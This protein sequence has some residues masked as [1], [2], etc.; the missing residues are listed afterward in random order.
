MWRTNLKRVYAGV[1]CT[2]APKSKKY[3]LSPE[4]G[5]PIIFIRAGTQLVALEDD[6]IV[7]DDEG[8]ILKPSY[9]YFRTTETIDPYYVVLD[10]P[11]QIG[12][13]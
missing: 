12:V 5:E 13:I 3:V 7:V 9:R 6:E 2:H 8:N 10:I 11:M 4:A 1:R